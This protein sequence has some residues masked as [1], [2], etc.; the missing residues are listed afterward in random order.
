ME[1]C[2]TSRSLRAS[3]WDGHFCLSLS[4][5]RQTSSWHRHSCLWWDRHS[6]LS[7]W[8]HH[9]RP[10]EGQECP[11][12]RPHITGK[13]AYATGGKSPRS[14]ARQR[15]LQLRKPLLGFRGPP[16][17]AVFLHDP[18]PQFAGLVRLLLRK[19]N[20]RRLAQRCRGPVGIVIR[21]ADGEQGLERVGGAFLLGAADAEVVLRPR[22]NF[23]GR[24]AGDFGIGARRLVVALLL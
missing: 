8:D 20:L 24:A 18:L 1:S 9:V 10:R 7:I 15:S 2:S 5:S 14:A 21:V 6:C 13:N 17:A 16:A 23:A 4:R 11:S 12:A 3:W 22:R 19:L